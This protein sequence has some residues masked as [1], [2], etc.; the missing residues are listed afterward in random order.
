MS[1][2]RRH[3][4]KTLAAAAGIAAMATSGALAQHTGHAATM[5]EQMRAKLYDDQA[6]LGQ[7]QSLEAKIA[8]K[9]QLLPSYIPW[10]DGVLAGSAE[11][12]IGVEDEVF[13]TLMV[14][15]IDTGDFDGAVPLADYVLKHGLSLPSRY[16]R[17]PAVLIAE[18]ANKLLDAGQAAP[19]EALSAVWPLTETRDMPDQV[20]AKLEKAIGREFARC[21]D[22]P[23]I[24]DSGMPGAAAA[25]RAQAIKHLRRAIELNPQIGVKT[26]LKV[27]EKAA[28]QQE[29]E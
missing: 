5:S 18:G 24:A 8:L 20:R 12:G 23:A 2:A 1:L 13:A 4:E 19:Q 29:S 26:R 21:S 15:R 22:D 16:Q 7:L 6:S 28:G 17:Q 3:R 25:Y 11:T 10:I 27:L 9:H 14:W